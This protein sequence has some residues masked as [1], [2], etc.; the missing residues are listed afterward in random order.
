MKVSEIEEMYLIDYLRLDDPEEAEKREIGI[1]LVSAR[2]YVKTYTG[3]SEEEIDQ[4]EDITI[5]VCILVADMF[6]NKSLYLDYK[7][8]ETN[9]TVEAILGMHSVN[10]I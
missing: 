5:A 4:H 8:K 7:S 2:E 3:L 6:E 10:L 9:K 1:A